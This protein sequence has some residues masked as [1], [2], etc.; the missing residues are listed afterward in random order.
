VQIIRSGALNTAVPGLYVY[1][2]KTGTS[3]NGYGTKVRVFIGITNYGAT[4]DLSGA[5]RGV[6]G[7][8]PDTLGEISVAAV[9]QSMYLVSDPVADR[10]KV[11]AVFLQTSNNTVAFGTQPTDLG[12]QSFGDITGTDGVLQ[13]TATDTTISYRLIN[14]VINESYPVSTRFYLIK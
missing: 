10:S 2:L 14:D 13:M 5:Y 7:N 3:T 9:A 4:T 12:D 6:I 8:A 1:D 11:G